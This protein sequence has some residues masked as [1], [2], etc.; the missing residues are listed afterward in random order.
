LAEEWR[1]AGLDR[2]IDG[3][4]EGDRADERPDRRPGRAAGADTPRAAGTNAALPDDLSEIATLL[5]LSPEATLKLVME[6]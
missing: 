4:S 2:R 6:I 1:L 3:G 5:N